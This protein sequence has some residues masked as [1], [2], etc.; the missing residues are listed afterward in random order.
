MNRNSINHKVIESNSICKQ[1]ERRGPY[2]QM[3]LGALHAVGI[4]S[5]ALT[6]SNVRIG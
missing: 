5:T 6:F 2:P 1:G 3:A 4:G